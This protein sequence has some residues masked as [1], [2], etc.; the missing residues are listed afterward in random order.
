MNSV[1]RLLLRQAWPGGD[2]DLLLRTVLLPDERA[3]ESWRRWKARRNLDD[4]TWDEHKLLAPVAAR[5]ASIDPACPYRPRVQGLAKAHWTHSQL[6]LRDSA[7][8]LDILLE[9]GLPVMLLKGGALLVAGIAGP[10]P[11][12]SGDLDV[13]VPR[14]VYPRAISLLYEHGWVARDSVEYARTSWRF[15]AGLNLRHGRHGDIDI[16]HQPVHRPRA[17]AEV[18]D[19]FWRRARPGVF[20]GRSILVPSLADMIVLTAA[21][22]MHPAAR[23]QTGGA[24]ACDLAQLLRQDGIDAAD[25][26][27]SAQAFDA[28]AACL[29]SLTY[30]QTLTPS[31]NTASVI[32]AL[33]RHGTGKRRMLSLYAGTEGPAWTAP[34]RRLA[35]LASGRVEGGF[36]REKKVVPR[37]HRQRI[38]FG[39]GKAL[40]IRG[41]ASEYRL[42]HEFEIGAERMIRTLLLT[43]E[44]ERPGIQ[45]RFRFD[46]AVDGVP[47]ARLAARPVFRGAGSVV[48]LSFRIPLAD[49]GRCPARLAVEALPEGD[50]QP[51]AGPEVVLR[52]KPV[53]FRIVGVARRR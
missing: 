45:R 26:V 28:I 8:A 25:V 33:A 50:L 39:A 3:A 18:L 7:A 16:H 17:S 22:A 14:S 32:E 34:L 37:R 48:R 35:R 51:D 38:R 11:R 40:P 27:A 2:A 46:V 29:A 9:A 30:L 10:G 21:H 42:R 23:R 53:P 44:L 19:A 20:H 6:M 4:V 47:V 13:L 49:P 31:E 12:I 15:H 1:A 36:E 43:I 5:L 52:V 24:W 41:D